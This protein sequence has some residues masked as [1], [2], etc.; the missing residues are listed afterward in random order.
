[1]D[2]HEIVKRLIG[3][4]EATGEH[5]VDQERLRNLRELT[6]LADLLL[7]DIQRAALDANRP[8][9]SMRAIGEHARDFLREVKE[10]DLN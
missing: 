10:A 9:A 2:F 3:P 8:E 4:V 7:G 5:G 6:E 1:M